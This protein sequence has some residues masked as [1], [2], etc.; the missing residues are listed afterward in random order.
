MYSDK[1]K[2]K[3]AAVVLILL[4]L[5]V[6]IPLSDLFFQT[7]RA[8]LIAESE[9][10]IEEAIRKSAT[11]CYVVEGIYP[12]DLEYLQ[13]NYGLQVNTDDYFVIYDAFADN[14]PPSVRVI[15]RQ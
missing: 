8:N 5:V 13:E 3:L 7:S 12:S 1:S 4:L 9:A 6:S 14:L 10:A 2:S 15:T 11:Q